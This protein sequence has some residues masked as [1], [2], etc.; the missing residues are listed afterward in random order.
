MLIMLADPGARAVPGT[1]TRKATVPPEAIDAAPAGANKPVELPIRM[2]PMAR[3]EIVD[4]P[5]LVSTRST[6]MLLPLSRE[7]GQSPRTF[8]PG[9]VGETAGRTTK[10]RPVGRAQ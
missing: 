10:V 3:L 9:A 4:L 2:E 7:S 6:R 5:L 8:V 1:E